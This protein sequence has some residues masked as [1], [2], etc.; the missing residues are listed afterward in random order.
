MRRDDHE[1]AMSNDLPD[2]ALYPYRG[3]VWLAV[4]LACLGVCGWI[5]WRLWP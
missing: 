2:V 5:I 4:I 3:C 1:Y